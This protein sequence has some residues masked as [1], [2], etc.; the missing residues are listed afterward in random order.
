MF[1]HNQWILGREARQNGW[2][3]SDLRMVRA[4]NKLQGV[5][6]IAHFNRGSKAI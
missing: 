2:E 1:K 5:R 4:T 3:L 6:E